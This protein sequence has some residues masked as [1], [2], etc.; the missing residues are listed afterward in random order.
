[1]SYESE[2]SVI[3]QRFDNLY[4]GTE[5]IKYANVAFNPPD[6]GI[7]L[8]HSVAD[9]DA[10]VISI[11]EDL[12][13]RNIG[14]ISVNIYGPKDGGTRALVAIADNV[15]GVYRHASFSGIQCRAPRIR[16]LGVIDDKYVINVSTPFFRDELHTV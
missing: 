10:F 5:P 1:M 3:E 15:A 16:K 4:P 7:Y 11:G 14:I 13:E 8:D 9:G 6:S 12:N 2:H